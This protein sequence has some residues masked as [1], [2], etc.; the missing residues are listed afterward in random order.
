MNFSF[1][2]ISSDV[3]RA[4]IVLGF[5]AAEMW[6]L[7]CVVDQDFVSAISIIDSFL[8]PDYLMLEVDTDMLGHKPLTMSVLGLLKW[9][10]YDE[11]K[12]LIEEVLDRTT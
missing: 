2:S 3:I 10:A 12:I 4:S 1:A 5:S 9:G 11:I 6:T 7:Q 8:L